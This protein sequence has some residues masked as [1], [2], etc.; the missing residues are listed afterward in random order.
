MS[1]EIESGSLGTDSDLNV[2]QVSQCSESDQI[3]E[4]VEYQRLVAEGGVFSIASC[5]LSVIFS[6][7]ISC[8][9]GKTAAKYGL[10]IFLGVVSA[11]AATVFLRYIVLPKIKHRPA[12]Y[13]AV[14]IYFWILLFGVLASYVHTARKFAHIYH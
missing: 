12:Q 7:L 5:L 2:C 13:C 9:V 4:E 1:L 14:I 6:L 10:H 8:E 11:I 3:V